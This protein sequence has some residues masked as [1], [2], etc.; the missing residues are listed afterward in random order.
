MPGSKAVHRRPWFGSALT[1][2]HRLLGTATDRTGGCPPHLVPALGMRMPPYG[3]ARYSLNT[4]M[5]TG[6][7]D[8]CQ[9][10]VSLF[11]T[12]KPDPSPGRLWQ[13]FWTCPWGRLLPGVHPAG[14]GVRGGGEL[15]RQFGGAHRCG[16]SRNACQRICGRAQMWSPLD[17][18]KS[19]NYEHLG[20]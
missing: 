20:I 1:T 11:F 18:V 9:S 13:A 4:L 6:Y 17:V 8:F 12:R 14:Q 15:H 7:I 5:T 2:V 3:F 10:A 19:I 16:P